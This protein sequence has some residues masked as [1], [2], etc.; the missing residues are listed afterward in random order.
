MFFNVSG[1]L[2]EPI[3]GTRRHAV[4]GY[5]TLSGAEPER[6]T[7]EVELLRTKAGILVRADLEITEQTACS[8]CLKPLTLTLPIEFEEEFQATVDPRS[9]H[10]IDEDRDPDAFLIDENHMLDLT[11]AVRQ[12][13]VA[14]EEI[15]P[16]CRPDCK[17]LCPRCGADLNL[18]EH[19]CEAAQ[20]DSR[21]AALA[22]LLEDTDEPSDA[23]GPSRVSNQRPIR[24]NVR[25][26]RRRSNAAPAK[27]KD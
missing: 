6:L 5:L 20:V 25:R 9:G 7:G 17:G 8:R 22:G 18:G 26:A 12:Y 16:L 27:R 14:T 13:R 2:Q 21:W 1:L 3:G 4:D 11:E 15:A 10:A 19:N 24:G 23:P